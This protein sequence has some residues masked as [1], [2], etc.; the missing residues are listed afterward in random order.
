MSMSERNKALVRRFYDEVLT[1]KNLEVVDELCA[2]DVVDH[3]PLPG[4]APGIEGLKQTLAQYLQAF[5][6]LRVSVGDLV[7]EGDLVAARL[8][9]SATHRGAFLGAKPTGKKVNL[10]AVDMVRVK[11]GKAAE[12]WHEGNDI[13]VMIELGVQIPVAG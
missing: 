2:R 6:D 13:V 10:T 3:N 12:I 9:G 5:P 4:Q 7:A 8:T 11:D 1:K